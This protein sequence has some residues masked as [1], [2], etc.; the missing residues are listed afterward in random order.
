[1]STLSRR[2]ALSILA[3]A[4]FVLTGCGGI[5]SN[6]PPRK[7]YQV[8]AATRFP[9]GLP[10]L[11][12]QLTIDSISAP[13]GLDT[14][15]IA[16]SRSPVS[17][18]YF[19]GVAWTD[20]VPSLLR[21]VLVQSFENSGAFSAIGTDT[22]IPR[23]DYLLAV[24]VRDFEA[25]YDSPTAP[26]VATVGLSL[27]LLK[28]PERRIVAQTLIQ[29]RQPAAANAIPQVVD[30]LDTALHKAASEAVGWTADNAAL[31]SRRR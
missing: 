7:L 18:D 28:L 9:A 19:A 8:T 12:A 1:M 17:I 13:A 11:A 30:A 15:R 10:R 2:C 23:T 21:T 24:E 20:R 29:T 25:A 3:A 5:L 27:K 14:E 6:P 22:F 26:P 16:L 31:S 4:A